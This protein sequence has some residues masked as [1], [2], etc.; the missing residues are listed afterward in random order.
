MI[1]IEDIELLLHAGERGLEF[2]LLLDRALRGVDVAEAV[3]ED[4]LHR[5]ALPAE[6]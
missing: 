1:C 4:V 2:A 6:P 5:L 3:L